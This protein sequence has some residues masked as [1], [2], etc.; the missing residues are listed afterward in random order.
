MSRQASSQGSAVLTSPV[1]ASSTHVGPFPPSFYDAANPA[2]YIGKPGISHFPTYSMA[3]PFNEPALFSRSQFPQPSEPHI[4]R[5]WSP[6]IHFASQQGSRVASPQ[7]NGHMQTLGQAAPSTSPIGI[8]STGQVSNQGST[9]L[10][11]RTR[12]QQERLQIQYLEEQRQQQ[13]HHQQQPV[14]QQLSLPSLSSSQNGARILQPVAHH[15]QAEIVNRTP[16]DHRQNPNEILQKGVDEAKA[17][18]SYSMDGIEKQED[19]K[20]TQ[21]DEG[22]DEYQAKSTSSSV[23]GA[24]PQHARANL[25]LVDPSLSARRIADPK[26]SHPGQPQRRYSSKASRFNVN[27]P[28]FEPRRLKNSG[29]FSFLGDKQAHKVTGGESLSLP[30]SDPARQAPNG[31]SQASK[32]NFAAPEFMPK[33]PVTAT[34]PSREFSFSALRP[35]LRPDAPAFEPCDSRNRSGHGPASEHNVVH[36]TKKIFGDVNFSEAIKSLKSK[37]V[38]IT[39]P[40]N[41]ESESKSRSDENQDGQEDESGRMT[42]ADGRQKRMRYVNPNI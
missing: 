28:K 24:G 41:K 17:C 10:L 27:A 15:N 32:W 30:S 2:S 23:G 37:A 9:D 13:H 34:V 12:E 29:V 4:P 22:Y 14:L 40:P 3:H 7:I 26:T 19:S 20:A 1:C 6:Q 33:D 35:V 5:T 42:Q 31:V 16:C 36:P 18:M 8:S 11:A 21:I 38:P 39:K 25:S